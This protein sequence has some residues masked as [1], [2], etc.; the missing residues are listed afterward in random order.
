MGLESKAK[1]AEIY[2]MPFFFSF[3]LSLPQII[4]L[5]HGDIHKSHTGRKILC[6]LLMQGRSRD[7]RVELLQHNI[8]DRL[9]AS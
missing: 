5:C 1:A 7:V 4:L 9:Q 2:S 3:A 8:I 6:G